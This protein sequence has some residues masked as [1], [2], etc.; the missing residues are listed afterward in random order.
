MIDH[1]KNSSVNEIP[2]LQHHQN[3]KPSKSA[4]YFRKIIFLAIISLI[5]RTQSTAGHLS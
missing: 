5:Q 3:V 4:Q 1:Q 2:F